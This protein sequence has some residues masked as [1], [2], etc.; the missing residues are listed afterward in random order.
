MKRDPARAG[1]EW[2]ENRIVTVHY[3]LLKLPDYAVL[4][5]GWAWHYM[6]PP[7][8]ESKL[9]HDHKDVDILIPVV[10][11]Q[12]FAAFF[13][14]DGYAKIWTKYDRF[15]TSGRPEKKYKEFYRVE[16]HVPCALT[17]VKVQI[18]VFL[19]D[20]PFVTVASCNL[21]VVEPKILLSFYSIK[22]CTT[23]DCTA[24][25]GARKLLAKGLNPIGRRELIGE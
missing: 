17:N 13:K 25:L 16:K 9:L 12:E 5:G 15:S 11:A 14:S 6:S 19:Q 21:K 24:V 10:R 1:D 7:H 3:E 4:S 18:D 8:R 20:V 22:Q 23:D 2:D